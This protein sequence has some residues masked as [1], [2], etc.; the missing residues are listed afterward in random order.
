MTTPRERLYHLLPAVYRLRDAEQGS[1]LRALLAVMESELETVE[2][3]LEELYESWFV[4][5]APE[6]VIP[7]IGELVGNRLL[8]E[9]AHSRRTDVARTLYYRRRKGTLP[10]LEELARDVTGWGAHAVEF[11]ELL[12]W[13]QNPNHLRYTFSPNPSLAH[14]AVDRVGTVN[15]RNADLLDRLGGPWDVVAHTVDVR[16]APP[17]A[18]VPYRKAPARTEEGWYGTRK[19]GLFLWRLRSFPLAGV[20]ARRADAPNAHGWHFSP[21]GAPAPLFTDTPAERDPARLARE[22]H[23]PAPIRPLAFRTDLEAYR[24]DYQPLPSDQRPAHSEWYGPNRSLNVIADGEPVLPEAVLCKDLDDWARPPAKQ[25]AIDVRR[26]RITFAAGEEPAVV[27]VAFAYGFGADL[28]GGPYDRRRSLADTATAEWVQR[29]AKGS[30][31]AT[32]QQALASWEAAGKPRGVIEITDSGVYG[33]ALAI[34][35]PADGS[36]VIQAAA[37]RL[38]SVRLIGDLAVSAPEPGARLRLNGLLVEGTLVLDGPVALEV[39]HCTLVP[40]RALDNQGEPRSPDRDSLMVTA[41]GVQT[42]EVTITSSITGAIRLPDTTR[43]LTIRDS[44][45][46]A[47]EVGGIPRAAIAASDAGDEP[48]PPATLER[49]TLFGQVNVRELTLASEV[50]FTAPVIAQRRQAGCVRFSYVP[51]G[52]QTP[53]RFQCQPDL[54]LAG[55][56]D[57]AEQ[58]RIR[59]RLVPTFTSERFGDPGYAQLRLSAALEIRAGAENG[60][61]M[62]AF[63]ALMQPQREANLRTRLEEY[64]P[65]GL[66]AALIYVT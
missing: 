55:V 6:W 62:G 63:S 66:E 1:P 23:V 60:S 37:G 42:P 47:H 54:V 31:V 25:V 43:Q 32:L 64:L 51:A 13:T 29:V 9:V 11:M 24:A 16:R 2:A 33:G 28:G 27:E 12:G 19:I 22:I 30:M 44:I 39:A 45:V 57:P 15:L 46:Q 50:I 26:G 61:E 10:M 40:G 52:S 56:T 4:E 21:L 34:E 65:F 49:V 18:Y 41:A 8:A 36:L 38:P 48:G 17:G 14:P 58:A 3:N 20:P 7:Y 53:R 35:L 59:G 5:T